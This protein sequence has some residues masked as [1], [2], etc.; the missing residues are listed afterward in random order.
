MSKLPKL[1]LTENKKGP[2]WTLKRDGSGQVVHR[3][4]TK[5]NAT[6]GGV[7]KRILAKQ[8]G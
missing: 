2:G 3:F 5:A 4:R 7:L 8:G 1:T 6:K